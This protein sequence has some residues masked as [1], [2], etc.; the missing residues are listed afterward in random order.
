MTP[1]LAKL[2]RL[3]GGFRT[4]GSAAV[5]IGVGLADAVGAIDLSPLLHYFVSDQAKLG[6]VMTGITV[7]FSACRYL[8]TTPLFAR[9]HPDEDDRRKHDLDEGH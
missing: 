4:I 2:K 8:T 5:F 3:G 7:W 1:V 6:A 9:P